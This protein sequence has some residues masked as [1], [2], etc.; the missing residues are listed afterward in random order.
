MSDTR[1]I[2]NEFFR[3]LGVMDADGVGAP[4]A[5]TIDWYVPGPKALPWTGHRH[6]RA[7]VREYFQTLWA[8]LHTEQ[9]KVSLDQLMIEGED[10]SA[11]GNLGHVTN[12]TEQHYALQLRVKDGAITNLQLYEDTYAVANAFGV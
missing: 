9:S 6:R 1:T 8:H 4:F 7:Q 5:E 3:R 10:A 2:V 12:I 11:L